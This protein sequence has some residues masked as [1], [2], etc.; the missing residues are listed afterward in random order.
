MKRPRAKL[1]NGRAMATEILEEVRLGMLTRF[2]LIQLERECATPSTAEKHMT[3]EL[4]HPQR[5]A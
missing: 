4:Q 1:V 3:A 2:K 5:T